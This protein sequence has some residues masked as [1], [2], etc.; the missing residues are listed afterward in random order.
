MNPTVPVANKLLDRIPQ[1][2]NIQKA[3]LWRAAYFDPLVENTSRSALASSIPPLHITKIY[4]VEVAVVTS[5]IGSRRSDRRNRE[6]VVA[7]C[8]EEKSWAVS[9][10][11]FPKYCMYRI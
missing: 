9:S 5:N 10:S 6:K 4:F 7:E 3:R 2:Y 8:V 1:A 11:H